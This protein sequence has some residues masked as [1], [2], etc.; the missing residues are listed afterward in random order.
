MSGRHLLQR[1]NGNESAVFV[2]SQRHQSQAEVNPS[3]K[4]ASGVKPAFIFQSGVSQ[5]VVSMLQKHCGN[6]VVQRALA[7]FCKQGDDSL[8]QPEIEQGINQVKGSGQVLDKNVQ[9]RMES[10][11]GVDFS[12]VRIHT[13][14]QSDFLNRSLNARAFTTGCDIFFGQGQYNPGSSA[15]QEL[16]AHELTHVVQQSDAIQTKLT[17]GQPDDAY[18]KEADQVARSVMQQDEKGAQRQAESDAVR[19]QPE[20]EEE[21][22]Q[23]KWRG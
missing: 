15:G 20:E 16:L 22:L 3:R 5:D 9:A 14:S 19:R 17:L 2:V 13:G 12:G 6:Q 11:F 8:V 23:T 1:V 10:S 18:E 4:P 7:V 21:L